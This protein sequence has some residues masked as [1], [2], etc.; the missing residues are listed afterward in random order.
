MLADTPTK[1]NDY[2]KMVSDI[3]PKT[4]DTFRDNNWNRALSK[5]ASVLIF[6]SGPFPHHHANRILS[7]PWPPE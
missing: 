5:S 6:V 2:K 4:A 1:P 3:I 7:V